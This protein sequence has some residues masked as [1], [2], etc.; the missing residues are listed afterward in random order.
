MRGARGIL[1]GRN[2]VFGIPNERR[3]DLNTFFHYLNQNCGRTDN[4]I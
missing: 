4:L 2:W 1:V 3:S